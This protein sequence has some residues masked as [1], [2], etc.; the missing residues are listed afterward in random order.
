MVI[1]FLFDNG[2]PIISN[3]LCVPLSLYYIS[4]SCSIVYTAKKIQ[5]YSFVINRSR[6]KP[7]LSLMPTCSADVMSFRNS[8]TV[9]NLPYI[10][11]KWKGVLPVESTLVS[12]LG[13]WGFRLSISWATRCMPVLCYGHPIIY[14]ATHKTYNKN[15]SI[16]G[17]TSEER[18][19]VERTVWYVN[20]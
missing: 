6:S 2:P 8:R 11:A 4:Q 7:W 19:E 16:E 17:I 12:K 15:F 18:L 20:L 10:T 3:N 5:N 9:W 1:Y 14:K 13:P